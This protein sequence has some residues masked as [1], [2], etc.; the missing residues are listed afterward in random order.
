MLAGFQLILFCF[1]PD[2]TSAM[3]PHAFGL[4]MEVPFISCELC[5]VQLGTEVI[6]PPGADMHTPID[7]STQGPLEDQVY[8]L[9]GSFSIMEYSANIMSGDTHAPTP[10]TFWQVPPGAP[11][12]VRQGPL[13][14]ADETNVRLC[15]VTASLIASNTLPWLGQFAASP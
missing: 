5:R 9:A 10:M 3:P 4:D 1:S 6:A 15:F 2:R 8:W 7:P 11:R 13:L 12:V 14:P